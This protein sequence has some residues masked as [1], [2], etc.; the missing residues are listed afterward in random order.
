MKKS[1]RWLKELM[2][3]AHIQGLTW[4]DGTNA[5]EQALKQWVDDWIVEY[6]FNQDIIK[7]GLDAEEM[8][9]IQHHC[10]TQVGEMLM[11][12]SS[13]YNLSKD[14]VSVNVFTLRKG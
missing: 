9:F 1:D 6:N 14:N 7:K 3:I 5:R 4:A 11:E 2:S 13:Y 12:E 10:A 8:R